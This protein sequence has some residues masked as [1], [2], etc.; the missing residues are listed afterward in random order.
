MNAFMNDDKPAAVWKMFDTAVG[1]NVDK[2]ASLS[3]TA[4]MA[5]GLFSVGLVSY[6]LNKFISTALQGS[7]LLYT[8]RCV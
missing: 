1:F 4:S 6:A 3:G 8:S 2:I 5:A 7:C